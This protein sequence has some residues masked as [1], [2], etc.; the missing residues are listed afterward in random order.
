MKE[1]LMRVKGGTQRG[2]M[3]AERLLGDYV[4]HMPNKDKEN[5]SQ[6]GRKGRLR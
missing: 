2:R 4:C 3:T 6:G 5:G 1:L